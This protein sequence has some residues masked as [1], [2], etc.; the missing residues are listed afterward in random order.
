MHS[1]TLQADP[2]CNWLESASL[3]GM[4]K[5]RQREGEKDGGAGQRDREEEGSREGRVGAH[6]K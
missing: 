1:G 5:E 3:E 6:T 4:L 2:I